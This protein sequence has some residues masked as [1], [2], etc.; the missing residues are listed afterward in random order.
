[1]T[2]VFPS[3][4]AIGQAAASTA[5]PVGAILM[6]TSAWTG[7]AALL[8][9][10]GWLTGLYAGEA[11]PLGPAFGYSLAI[12][13][14]WA[15][16]TPPLLAFG[17]LL[18]RTRPSRVRAFGALLAGYGGAA[19]IHVSAFSLLFWPI[20]GAGQHDDLQ[21]MG[22]HM[23]VRNIGLNALF[24]A[25]LVA[26]GW[27]RDRPPATP[28]AIKPSVAPP[29]TLNAR[30]RGRLR[31]V[32]LASIHWIR[33]AGNHA[34][35]V[36]DDGIVLLD[37]SLAALERRLPPQTFVRIHRTAIVRLS[38]VTEVRSRGH[39]DA[40]LLLEGGDLVRLSRRYRAALTGLLPLP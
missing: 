13:S 36:T 6:I 40:D 10:Q 5:R 21:A 37:D 7:V 28:G 1:M 15:M 25:A 8:T 29:E 30:S 24:F 35:A 11:I 17:A 3:R 16:M 23:I 27:L 31:L 19:L 38:A 34:E 32:R 20:Y 12:A 18:R 22:A 14:I 9:L 26:L 4:S 33:A 2:V 39:G